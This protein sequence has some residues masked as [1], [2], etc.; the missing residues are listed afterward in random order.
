VRLDLLTH[1]ALAYRTSVSSVK[2]AISWVC[3]FDLSH[4]LEDGADAKSS[5]ADLDDLATGD[6][7]REGS[8]GG[9][10]GAGCPR[11]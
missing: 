9:G 2:F 6:L 8:P 11:V 5:A 10:A 7:E 3:F 4:D 1:I